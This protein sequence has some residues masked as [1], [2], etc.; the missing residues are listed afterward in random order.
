MD[1]ETPRRTF[2]RTVQTT[3]LGS[4]A[5]AGSASAADA[6]DSKNGWTFV[7]SPTTKTLTGVVHTADGPYAVGSGG[8]IFRRDST[9]GWERVV[10]AGPAG[11]SR[12]LTGVDVTADGRRIWYVGGS[13]VIGTYDVLSRTKTDYS[14]PMGKTSTWED[15]AVIGLAGAERV[16]F[17]NGSGEELSGER[18]SD[19]SIEYEEVTKPGGG[20][21]IPGI[22]FHGE[23]EGRCCDTSQGV[24]ETSDGMQYEQ[25][26]ISNASDAFYDVASV[27]PDDANVVAG[28]GLIYVFDGLRWTPLLVG[29]GAIRSVDRDGDLGLA[30][31]ADGLVYERQVIGDW[32]AIETPTAKTLNGVARSETGVDVAV[33][34][35]GVIV[36]R[37]ADPTDLGFVESLG[38]DDPAREFE[39]AI[40]LS[41]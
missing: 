17:V 3:V 39:D 7:D 29:S 1:S 40:S 2:L 23:T 13:G 9:A 32:E 11:K 14:A 22:D 30:A 5:L 31:G 33:G 27:G 36:E 12:P 16:Y 10:D 41:T 6:G 37:T 4:L 34:N 15:V 21:T 8:D 19:G 18:Q 20:S 38:L 28:G 25:I 35:S 26:G 24:Y